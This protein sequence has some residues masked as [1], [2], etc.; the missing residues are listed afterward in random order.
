MFAA[1][2]SLSLVM[3]PVQGNYL[4]TLSDLEESNYVLSYPMK[5]NHANFHTKQRDTLYPELADKT[6]P[7]YLPH[8]AESHHVLNSLIE[9]SY[10]PH[11][12]ESYIMS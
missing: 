4:L 11:K 5:R 7:R 1:I 3:K 9:L 10:L 12:A 2:A 8:T 6:K